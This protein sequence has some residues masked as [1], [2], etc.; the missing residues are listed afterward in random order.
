M[1]TELTPVDE[2]IAGFPTEV[3]SILQTFRST[4]HRVVPESGEKINYKMPTITMGDKALLYFA[5]WKHHVGIYPI[6]RFDD[7]L[8]AEV[9]PYR[10]AKD[11]VRFP[12][13]S[14]VPFDLVERLVAELVR[15]RLA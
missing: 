5:G 4:I 9:A 6:P 15:R 10:A 13:R 12:L 7:A 3:Q 1:T 2:Y 8:E 14:S 11:T